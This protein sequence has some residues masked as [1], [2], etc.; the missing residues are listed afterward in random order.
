MSSVALSV[1]NL[2]VTNRAALQ[3]GPH[4]GLKTVG[5]ISRQSTVP[6]DPDIDREGMEMNTSAAGRKD[7]E[8]PQVT[9]RSALRLVSQALQSSLAEASA[10]IKR[11]ARIAEV[12][13][14]TAAAWFYGHSAPSLHHRLNLMAEIPE[15]AGE[16]R[17]V[18]QMERELH[19]DL[20]RDIAALIQK[21]I[22]R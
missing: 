11:I 8:H 6:F 22:R 9:K 18:T 4:N 19:D 14:K 2:K 7:P 1:E 12:D 15:L 3:R 20:Q 5:N 21:A 17:R 16:V 10:P 13:R